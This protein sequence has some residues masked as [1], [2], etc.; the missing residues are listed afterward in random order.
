MKFMAECPIHSDTDDG[1]WLDPANIAEFAR[2]AEES[3]IDGIQFTD[4]PAPSKKWLERGGHETYEPFVALGF[5]AAVTHRVRVM[6][7]LTVVP[8]RNP[9]LLAK[10]MT[11]VDLLSAGR[12]TFVL[13]TGYL[14]SE[15]AAL[16][17]DFE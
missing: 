17:V 11:T 8:Y 5:V 7:N 1:A 10:A 6:T 15:F 2:V 9:L 3:G 12:A 16:G 14:R 13:G 4:H